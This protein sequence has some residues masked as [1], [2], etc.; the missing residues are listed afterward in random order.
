M[1][2][3]HALPK[4]ANWGF[5]IKKIAGSTSEIADFRSLPKAARSRENR[6]SWPRRELQRMRD[7][8]TQLL[9]AL[10][11]ASA[12]PNRSS[13]AQKY[14]LLLQSANVVA[15]FLSRS[16]RRRCERGAGKSK[17]RT[18]YKRRRVVRADGGW[19]GS[20]MQGYI[21]PDSYDSVYQKNFRVTES[22]F[23]LLLKQLQCGG[24]LL[25]NKNRNP[26]YRIPG[27]FKLAVCLYFF[28]QGTGWKAA[29]DC[30]SLGEATVEKYVDE[31]IDG[32]V[33]VLGPIYM[34]KS[35]PSAAGLQAL[36]EGTNSKTDQRYA[37]AGVSDSSQ[38]TYAATKIIMVIKGDI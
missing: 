23:D 3:T 4:L 31:F 35:P 16:K 18:G 6:G 14:L 2:A 34:P 19:I 12:L 29:A 5:F 30:A 22:T 38:K 20:T 17:K 37:R 32:V 9:L 27:R 8:R 13:Y 7:S 33:A 21:G 11:A 25:D 36:Y 1:Q 15:H 24:Y 10:L 26:L 28:A